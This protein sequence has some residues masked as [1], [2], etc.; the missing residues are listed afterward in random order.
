MWLLLCVWEIYFFPPALVVFLFSL[1]GSMKGLLVLLYTHTC[2]SV[3]CS[4]MSTICTY[5]CVPFPLLVLL[6]LRPTNPVE[7]EQKINIFYTYSYACYSLAGRGGP[8]MLKL[9]I[10]IFPIRSLIL[11]FQSPHHHHQHWLTDW[12]CTWVTLLLLHTTIIIFTFF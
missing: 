7:F 1:L 12:D 5:T 6:Q 4:F 8:P 11:F 9:F 2:V 3:R 10:I